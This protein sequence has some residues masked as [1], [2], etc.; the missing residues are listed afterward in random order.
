[1]SAKKGRSY[2]KQFEVAAPV[3]AVWR[4]I[5]EGEE[6]TRWFCEEASCAPGVR[7]EQRI[8]W[9]GGAKGTQVITIW[10]PN[11]HLRTEAVRPDL[12]KPAPSEPYGTDWYLT[13]EGGVTRVR[14]VASGFG[15]GPEWDHEY[16]GTFH[17]WD[18]FHKTLKHYLEHHRG[19]AANNVVIYAMLEVPPAEAWARL[20]SAD[21]FV[22]DGSLNE[23]S[24]GAP[25]RF[26]TS[27]GDLFS[28][29]VGLYVPEKVFAAVVDNLNKSMLRIEMATVPGH[30]HFLYFSLST[31]GLPE[32]DVDALG[33][34]LK[35]I[36]YGLFPQKT[37]MPYPGCSAA[38]HEA[39]AAGKG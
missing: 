6:L 15:E 35:A 8:D 12:G 4:A 26:T 21:G 2:E 37:D 10:E 13:H 17:G 34:R 32:A 3:E 29:T 33:S 31:W 14:M 11:E 25:F 22:R 27:R 9:G 20:T 7:G 24:S 36:V 19:E 30:G 39:A 1:M 38:E 16:D 28:G 18:M 23:L 5:T